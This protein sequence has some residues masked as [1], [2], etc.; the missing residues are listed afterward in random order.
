MTLMRPTTMYTA[1]GDA[2]IAYQVVGEGSHD[3]VSLMSLG[4]NCESLWQIP[5]MVDHLSRMASICRVISFD[6]RGVGSS[7]A[8][9]LNAIPTW[10]N[11]AE[12]A[13]AV[14]DAVGSSKATLYAGGENGPMALLFAASHP[15]RV[16]NLV[17]HTT[18]ARF[19][20]TDDYPIGQQA[21]GFETF[22]EYYR[23]LWGTPDLIRLMMPEFS[24]D[25]AML[26]TL[27][28]GFRASATPRA[29][30]AQYEYLMRSID[31][32]EALSL[33]KAP[34]VVLHPRDSSFISP[35]HGRYLAEHIEG[36]RFVELPGSD[37]PT[38]EAFD[39]VF[40]EV[41]EL[42]TG[43]RVDEVDRVLAT[44]LFTD[45]V[46]S[47]AKA[48]TLGDRRWRSVLDTHDLVVREQIRRFRG[49]EVNT[50]GDG[51]VASFDGPARAIRCAQSVVEEGHAAGIDIRA[52]LHAGECEVRGEDLGGL[53]VHIAAR[54]GAIARPRQVFVSG[55]LKDLVVGSG[56][57][58]ENEGEHEL[59]GV[60]GVWRIFALKN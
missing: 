23:N 3:L 9:P 21:E 45:I 25:R 54:V 27:A 4:I 47:T 58:F 34:T 12:D 33:I 15:E 44:V 52:G 24:E 50:T 57:E 35:D 2:D 7:D 22:V 36:A 18:Y 26:E 14:M 42:L 17:L 16:S 53:A 39:Q 20:A 19:L 5:F 56:F 1:F 49:R 46:D 11:L 60:P 6:R 38:P 13:G 55:T 51:F 59:K 31:A 37:M 28:A 43:E 41:A 10:E 29:A 40:S 32:R 8:V 30:A 48:A